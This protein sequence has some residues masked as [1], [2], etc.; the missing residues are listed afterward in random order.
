M[1]KPKSSC[2]HLSV[3]IMSHSV[4]HSPYTEATQF[5]IMYIEVLPRTVPALE[6]ASKMIQYL[7]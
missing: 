6:D 5:N 1:N 7:M 4:P 3:G 2:F